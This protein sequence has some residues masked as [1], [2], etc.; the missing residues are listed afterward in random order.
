MPQSANLGST[1]IA[2]CASLTVAA[3]VFLGLRLYCKRRRGRGFWW[4]DHVLI[5]A[6]ISLAIATALAIY[7]VTLGFG[8]EIEDVDPANVP[9]I[10]L[11]GTIYGAF[12]VFAIAWSKTS[13]A[14][15]LIRLVDGR[16]RK[17][18]WAIIVVMNLLMDLA[19]V[20]LFIQCNPP[21]K[22]WNSSMPGTC[23]D[24]KVSTY[25]NIFAGVFSG[26]VDVL[27]CILPW[28]IIWKLPMRTR[29]KLGVGIA[30]TFGIFAAAAAAVKSV[31]TIGLSKPNLTY[32][33]VGIVMWAVIEGAVTIMAASIPVM[34][35]LIL[36]TGLRL[37][38][39]DPERASRQCGS[40]RRLNVITTRNKKPAMTVMTP[41]DGT[42]ARGITSRRGDVGNCEGTIM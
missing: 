33:R 9:T 26:A 1:V 23:W 13:F 22:V 10:V 39:S 2:V 5:A 29:E 11:T 31:N 37:R 21:E 36:D 16:T 32:A 15:T 25:Y 41:S 30:L 18:L 35:M 14:L 40:L 34:R 19:I 6:W 17:L 42:S 3:A 4:D 38:R 24:P 8:K 12:A 7:I 27:L 20:L 28:F